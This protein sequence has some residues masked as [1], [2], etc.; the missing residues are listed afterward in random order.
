M[1]F[2][3]ERLSTEE[4]KKID[5]TCYLSLLGY[6]PAKTI[7][8]DFWYRSP[9]R[10]EHEPSFKVNRKLN[11]WF[12]HGLGKGGNIIDFGILYHGCTVSELLQKLSTNF[13][14]QQP[15]FLHSNKSIATENK[16]KILGDF[17]LTSPALL[18]YLEERKIPIEI[19]EQFCRE[20]RYELNNKT[21][22]G[23][24]FKNNSGGFEIRNPYFKT[25]SS[26]KDITI[27]DNGCEEALIFEGFIDFLSFKATTK[28]PPENGQDFVVLNSVSF[29]ERARPFMEN[30]KHIRLYLDRDTTGINCTQRALSMSPQYKD[31]STI[32]KNYKDFNDWIM[33]PSKVPKKQLGRKL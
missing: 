28:N 21:Y 7:R 19:A 24:G 3:K 2:R 14:L 15:T 5:M 25:S 16:I 6:N 22:F 33:N 29:F 10:D 12:D 18:R 9:L 11:L 23:I 32:Y 4:A 26:P 17:P 20:V 13:S 31:E 8:V 27:I 1:D 30:H